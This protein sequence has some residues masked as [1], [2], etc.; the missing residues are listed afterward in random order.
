MFKKIIFL[1]VFCVSSL[2]AQVPPSP[3]QVEQKISPQ[4][5]R[6]GELVTF[7]YT[8]TPEA[9]W[10]VFSL[11]TPEGGPLATE[12]KFTE[13]AP[14]LIEGGF[15]Q[16]T[17]KIVWDEGFEMNVE[18]FEHSGTFTKSFEVKNIKTGTYNLK[19][20]VTYQLCDENSCLPP[21]TKEFSFDLKI[22]E[23]EPRPEFAMASNS[24]NGNLGA[25][26]WSFIWLAVSAGALALLTPC[27]FP[28]I[29]IT[30]SFFTKQAQN[31]SNG[32][33]LAIVYCLGIISTYVILGLLLSIFLG[34]GGANAIAANPWVNLFITA[35]FVV[36]AMSLF[37]MFELELPNS[38]VNYFN[39]KSSTSSGYWGVLLMGF[40]FTL[41][42]FTCTVQFVGLLMVAVSQGSL[43]MPIVGMTVFATVFA[44]PFFVLAL[45]PQMIASLPKSGGWLNSTKV[46]MGFIELAAALKF[47]SNTDLIF[48][49]EIVTRPFML[50]S[51]VVIFA[52][53]GFYI[54]GKLR[55]PHDSKLEVIT[56]PRLFLSM[57]F[58][59]A[60]LYLS[61]GLI[62]EPLHSWVDSYLPPENYGVSTAQN[63]ESG[64]KQ[65]AIHELKWFDEY[66]K[67]LEKA[68]ETGK[69]I[70]IDFTGYT[71]TNCRL[72]EKNVMGLP[73]ILPLL[74]DE[75]VLV[76]LYTDGGEN[77]KEKQNFQIERFQTTALPFYA[78][79]NEKDVEIATF[80]GYTNNSNDFK[81]FLENAIAKHKNELS[82][83]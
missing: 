19:G 50:T 83:P 14:F 27:V 5:A 59:T 79:L 25:D 78:V 9:N 54:L 64:K 71:C 26:F 55:L 63:K 74:R 38:F 53:T 80:P 82:Q 45:F 57:F 39:L 41:A 10:H 51:W 76:Q 13:K 65:L 48:Q 72:M 4:T 20:E 47:L 33:K 15:S 16:N 77:H 73:E 12:I 18:F 49:W 70:F 46:V 32:V 60:S 22:E 81:V 35:L 44:L 66:S 30:V 23:G 3:V 29:P 31:K 52:L 75:F 37:G 2:N 43:V 62:G 28:M 7:S 1:V 17:P 61:R 36:F 40:T 42:S 58:L 34:G 69:P 68:K 21:T 24:G 67:G 11:T 8:I 6:N 56:V